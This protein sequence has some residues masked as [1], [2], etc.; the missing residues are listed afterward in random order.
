MGRALSVSAT[1]ETK[2]DWGLKIVDEEELPGEVAPFAGPT[3]AQGISSGRHIS[4][5]VFTA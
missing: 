4:D 1:A 3:K 2:E 5:S